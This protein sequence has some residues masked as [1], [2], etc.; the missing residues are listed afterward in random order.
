MAETQ[1]ALENSGADKIRKSEEMNKSQILNCVLTIL[2]YPNFNPLRICYRFTSKKPFSV[3]VLKRTENN[4]D[5]QVFKCF[6]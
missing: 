4:I 5:I 3:F 6:H 2:F 1:S